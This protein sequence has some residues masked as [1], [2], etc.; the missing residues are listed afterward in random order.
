MVN[1][2]GHAQDAAGAGELDDVEVQ[3]Q[4]DPKIE[5]D[6]DRDTKPGHLP[7]LRTLLRHGLSLL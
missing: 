3:P 5:S 7:T 1:G 4:L 2:R 6:T